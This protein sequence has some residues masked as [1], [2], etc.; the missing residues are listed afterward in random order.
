[1]CEAFRQGDN[2]AA[3]VTVFALIKFETETAHFK[4]ALYLNLV[5]LFRPSS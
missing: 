2:P 3:A 1:V 5:R 4:T